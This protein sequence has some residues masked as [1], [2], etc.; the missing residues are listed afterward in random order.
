LIYWFLLSSMHNLM[1]IWI[2]QKTLKLSTWTLE[3][4]TTPFLWIVWGNTRNEHV[5]EAV[6]AVRSLYADRFKRFQL[7]L[8]LGGS[9]FRH[10]CL[11]CCYWVHQLWD[12]FCLVSSLKRLRGS[13][14]GTD[15]GW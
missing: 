5:L 1:Q 7:K 9:L 4:V 2:H 10:S 6:H 14:T 15:Q 3:I 11:K 12:F 8:D 13:C